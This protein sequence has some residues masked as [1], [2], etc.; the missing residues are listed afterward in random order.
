MMWGDNLPS[1]SRC[2][3]LFA[4]SFVTQLLRTYLHVQV[5]IH[6]RTA[7]MS[8]GWRMRV[9]LARCVSPALSRSV[10]H[11]RACP[12]PI[13]CSAPSSASAGRYS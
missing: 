7:D 2:L 5:T 10:T 3:C 6:K 1:L 9:A 12:R 4:Y 8:G 13:A 11:K